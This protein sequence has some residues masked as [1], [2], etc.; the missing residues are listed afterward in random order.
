MQ[1]CNSLCGDDAVSENFENFRPILDRIQVIL[2]KEVV[3]QSE[4][5]S[6]T[7]DGTAEQ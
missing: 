1:L 3:D 2:K 4:P 5:A 6:S 7:G